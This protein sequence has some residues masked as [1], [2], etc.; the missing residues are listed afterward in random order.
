MVVTGASIVTIPETLRRFEI[1]SPAF[2]GNVETT[3]FTG[4][5]G[6]PVLLLISLNV[7]NTFFP[8]VQSMLHPAPPFFILSLGLV[9]AGGPIAF[10]VALPNPLLPAGI[11]GIS[12][13]E[14]CVV[15]GNSGFGLLSAPSVRTVIQAGL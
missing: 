2:E 11:E 6:E 7:T 15:P 5:P 8:G 10:G 4:I 9:P 14:Q 13:Y 3:L 12:L 1:S